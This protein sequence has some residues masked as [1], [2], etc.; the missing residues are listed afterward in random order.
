[1]KGFR[2]AKSTFEIQL[3][4]KSIVLYGDN[5]TG[6]SSLTDSFEWYYSDKVSHLSGSEIKLQEALR[7]A[8]IDDEEDSTVTF[9]YS[10]TKIDNCKTLKKTGDKYLTTNSNGAIEFKEYIEKTQGENIILRYQFLTDFIDNTK[11]DKLKYLSNIIGYS[12][13][14]KKKEILGKSYRHLKSALKSQNF[15]GQ[16]A[17]QKQILVTKLGATVSK[18]DDFIQALKEKLKAVKLDDQIH[19]IEDIDTVLNILKKPINKKLSDEIKFLGKI[20]ST[21]ST[22]RDEIEKVNS[23]YDSY[24]NEFQ[25]ISGDVNSIRQTFLNELLVNAQSIIKRKIHIAPSCPLCLQDKNLENLTSEIESRLKNIEEAA[26]KKKSFDQ[27]KTLCADFSKERIQR[28]QFIKSEGKLKEEENKETKEGIDNLISLYSVLTRQT[29]VKVTSGLSI[30]NREEAHLKITDFDFLSPITARIKEID[31]QLK[32]D[33][34]AEM[35]ADIVASRDSYFRIQNL[36]KEK[37]IYVSQSKSLENIYDEFVK[38]QKQELENFVNTFSARINEFY[39]F[40]NP[41]APFQEIRIVT[42]GED[43]ELDGITVEYKYNEDWVSP[44]QKYFSESHLN[45]FGLAFFLASVEAFNHVNKFIVLDDVISSFDSTHRK[46]FADLIFKEFSDYQVIL[47]THEIEWFQNMV[48]PLAK[49]NGWLINEIKWTLDKGTHLD[50]S[51]LDLKDHIIT[52]LKDSKIDNLGNPIRKYIEYSLKDIAF[53]TDSKM[54]FQY[55]QNN[56]QRMPNELL[57][58]IRSEIK[59]RSPELKAKFDIMDRISSSSTLSNFY[60]HDSSMHPKIGD[61]RALWADIQ[62]FEDIFICKESDCTKKNVS[63]RYYDSVEKKIR[64]GC[65]K[66]K[67]E[68]KG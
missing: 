16:I 23:I 38:V 30:V 24:H 14:I 33:N 39:Q 15:E 8:T 12:E 11:G 56:E 10:D 60:S 52:S 61:I 29:E 66:T 21:I 53:R 68:W 57:Q 63:L 59:K 62:E 7:N 2:G 5:G 43:D 54:S 40:M 1:M 51:P 37:A 32:K 45:C 3:N 20:D 58:G 25:I 64:C 41:D 19:K 47:L 34:T 65:G 18:E 55:N 31:E 48:T 22:I 13:V 46:R 49:S 26:K 36:T 4:G 17:T 42:I 50:V 44:P 6:K 67:Y 27:A 28:L 9:E 35:Y